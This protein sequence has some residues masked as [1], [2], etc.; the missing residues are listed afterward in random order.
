MYCI[1]LDF[2]LRTDLEKI[3]ICFNRQ[4]NNKGVCLVNA[5]RVEIIVK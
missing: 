5:N 3:D 2:E 1:L 4:R